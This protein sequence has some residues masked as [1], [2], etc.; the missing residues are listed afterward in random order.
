MFRGVKN[1]VN[2]LGVIGGG[3]FSFRLPVVT[4]AGGGEDGSMS[5]ITF[6]VSSKDTDGDDIA[7]ALLYRTQ[8]R[9]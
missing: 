9:D 6:S 2:R 4:A 8:R 7:A 5:D 1:L 3:F